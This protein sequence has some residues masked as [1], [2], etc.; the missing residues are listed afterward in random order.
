[1]F[2]VRQF[3]VG[4]EV[5]VEVDQGGELAFDFASGSAW[6]RGWASQRRGAGW[7]R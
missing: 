5:A 2:L 6:R 7:K 4:M 3:G 1:M